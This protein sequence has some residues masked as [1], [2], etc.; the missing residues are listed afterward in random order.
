MPTRLALALLF[1]G[2]PLL[3]TAPA[4]IATPALAAAPSLSTDMPPEVLSWRE[5][6]LSHE[7]YQKLAEQWRAYIGKHPRSAVAHVQLAR[8]LRYA[9]DVPD[10]ERNEF[11]RKAY[12]LDPHCPEALEA[13]ASTAL[14]SGAPLLTRDEA[15]KLAWEAVERA[16]RWTY[17]HFTLWSLCLALGKRDEA[18]THLQSLLEK[19]AFPSP[20]LDFAHNLL[21]SAEPKATI[22]TN[23]DNDTYPLLALQTVRGIRTD[24]AVVNLSLL[25]LEGYPQMAWDDA[26]DDAGPFTAK[27]IASLRDEWSRRRGKAGKPLSLFADRIVQALLEKVRDGRWEQPVY[28]AV[29]VMEPHLKACPLARELEGIL[30]RVQK[31]PRPAPEEKSAPALA[32]AKTLRLFRRDFRLDSATD[33][34]FPWRPDCAVR[35]L[36]MNYTAVLQL[37]GSKCAEEGDRD[38]VRFALAKAIRILDFHGQTGKVKELARYWKELDPENA[39]IDRWL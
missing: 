27:E 11:I 10:A 33:L 32:L 19:S 16:P 4:L 25:N 8:A 31:R 17:P 12:E 28:Y 3:T 38:C 39:E 15:Y 18:R 14:H 21:V 23:G 5:E 2:G 6:I 24:V 7:A 34:V 36:L 22:L 1:L 9:G 29:T 26:F 35:P 37:A 13:M 30:W 20:L